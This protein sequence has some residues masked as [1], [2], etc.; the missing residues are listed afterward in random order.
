MRNGKFFT[1]DRKF[2]NAGTSSRCGARELRRRLTL[3]LN[4]AV[5]SWGRPLTSLRWSE[6]SRRERP[7][8]CPE[9]ILLGQIKQQRPA[10]YHGQ[11]QAEH[12]RTGHSNR[13]KHSHRSPALPRPTP[14]PRAGDIS[15][16]TLSV[17]AQRH[18]R[19]EDSVPQPCAYT[20][21]GWAKKG[22]ADD[23]LHW[24]LQVRKMGSKLHTRRAG[25]V[26]RPLCNHHHEDA[27]TTKD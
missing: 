16:A 22:Q 20:Q 2:L 23:I 25:A 18:P 10:S 6:S 14:I 26:R 21:Q 27:R 17:H 3:S 11:A 19:G 5:T 7:H 12:H 24:A 4:F 15:G 8:T 9:Q 13:G 1:Q